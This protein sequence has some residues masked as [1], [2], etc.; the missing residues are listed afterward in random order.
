MLPPSASEAQIHAAVVAYCHRAMR[1]GVVVHHSPN[2]G[3]RTRWEGA[4][5]KRTGVMA[6][7][8]D[9]LFVA[10]GR[11]YGLELKTDRGRLT[12]SQ[13][14]AHARLKDAGMK[15]EIARSV[16]EA[17]AVLRGW[18]LVRD[19]VR[20]VNRARLDAEVIAP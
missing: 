3:K 5:L 12:P 20:L 16:D 19:D 9:L 17:V 6:G 15:V 7:F 1:P 2:E 11:V 10:D 18:N 14:I 13:A 4:Q 8:P